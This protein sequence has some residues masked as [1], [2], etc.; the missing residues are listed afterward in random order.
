MRIEVLTSG[1]FETNSYI[2]IS[3]QNHALLI[4][5]T[6]DSFDFFI[7]TIT[8]LNLK[9][10][11]IFLTHSHIDH[12][13]DAPKVKKELKIPVYV[14]EL[15]KENLINPGADGL[16]FGSGYEGVSPDQTFKDGDVFKLEDFNFMILHTPGHS[17]GSCCFYF[18]DEAVL[19]SGDTLFRG[20]YG[21]IS[22]STSEPKKMKESLKRLSLLPK[23][24]VVWPGHGDP[25][26][27]D[28]EVWLNHLDEFF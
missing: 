16:P 18:P 9:P 8:E 23:E 15:D 21:N 10:L 5:P 11:A 6:F 14:H 12:I 13:V 2:L 1:P 26:T 7:N 28:E 19:I 25:T 27:I 4:D 22:F 24:T 3:D 20:T 17:F